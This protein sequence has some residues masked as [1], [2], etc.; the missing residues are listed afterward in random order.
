MHI[1]YFMHLIVTFTQN[2]DELSHISSMLLKDDGR[3]EYLN[4]REA[5]L[6]KVLKLCIAVLRIPTTNAIVTVYT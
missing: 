2:T 5:V 4:E 6:K 3:V 1:S